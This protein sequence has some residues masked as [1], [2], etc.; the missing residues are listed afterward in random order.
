[1][2]SACTGAYTVEMAAALVMK[3]INES[4]ALHSSDSDGDPTVSAQCLRCHDAWQ[5]R[6]CALPLEDFRI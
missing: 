6:D 1:M 3:T 4:G 2:S 5:T